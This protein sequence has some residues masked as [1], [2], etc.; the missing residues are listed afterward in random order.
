MNRVVRGCWWVGLVVLAAVGCQKDA[1]KLQRVAGKAAEKVRAA[2]GVAQEPMTSG[3]EVLKT[4]VDELSP[5]ARV[6]A[7]L[8]WDKALAGAAIKVKAVGGVVELKGSVATAELKERA[9]HLAQTT[10]GVETVSDSLEVTG[11]DH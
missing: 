4:G 5:E 3:I 1:D 11:A 8:K 2:A 9:M 10:V 6:A 7:R